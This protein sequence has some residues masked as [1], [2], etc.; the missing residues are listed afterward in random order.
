MEN[1]LQEPG[2]QAQ[3]QSLQGLTAGPF[4]TFRQQ[5][6][7]EDQGADDGN[8]ENDAGKTH[9]RIEAEQHSETTFSHE[10]I[11]L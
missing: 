3:V 8:I 5:G 1:S 4:I 2:D 9:N 11:P 7:D 10:K 6:Q